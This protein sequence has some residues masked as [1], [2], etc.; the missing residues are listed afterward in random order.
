MQIITIRDLYSADD[1]EVVN[2]YPITTMCALTI[3][4][5]A[6]RGMNMMTA[7][8]STKTNPPTWTRWRQLDLAICTEQGFL[9]EP[10]HLRLIL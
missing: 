1:L 9:G 4:P 5:K 10:V 6:P 8:L 3:A 2:V 7:L